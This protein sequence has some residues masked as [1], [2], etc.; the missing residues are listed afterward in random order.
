MNKSTL[1]RVLSTSGVVMLGVTTVGVVMGASS[2][3]AT[4]GQYGT[5]V[6]HAKA[7]GQKCPAGKTLTGAHFVIT[8]IA[9]NEPGEITVTISGNGTTVNEDKNSPTG[10]TA[11]YTATGLKATDTV[12]GATAVV[13]YDWSGQFNLSHLI[14][15]GTSTPPAQNAADVTFTEG[16]GTCVNDQAEYTKPS[17]TIPESDVAAYYNKVTNQVVAAGPHMVDFG[18]TVTIVAKAKTDVPLKGQTEWSHTFGS[19]PTVECSHPQQ[20]TAFAQADCDLVTGG[21]GGRVADVK[22]TARLF[23]EKDVYTGQSADV[24]D[25]AS[26]VLNSPAPGHYY[27]LVEGSN[28]TSAKSNTFTVSSDCTPTPP[29]DKKFTVTWGAQHCIPGANN[30]TVGSP[31]VSPKE[32]AT[33][34]QGSWKNGMLTKSVTVKAGYTP[35]KGV[36]LSKPYTDNGSKCGA[37]TTPSTPKP[38]TYP[39]AAHTDGSNMGL[40]LLGVGGVLV[41]LISGVLGAA[42]GRV[43]PSALRTRRQ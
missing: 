20:L 10:K 16:T 5:K 41:L 26:F 21:A 34:N 28:G 7:L 19:K 2:A 38:P 1:T 29:T 32:A 6:V 4:G 22:Y 43:A 25:D 11:H 30:D 9:P 18:D 27:V 14:C 17:F 40:L 35:A 24:A 36:Q 33:V 37:T 8:Q 3:S 23:T 15:G 42:N 39:V 13:P 12:D 31:V